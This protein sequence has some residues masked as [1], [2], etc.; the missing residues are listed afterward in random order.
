MLITREIDYAMRI[1]R[2][3]SNGVQMTAGEI[4][5]QQQIPQQF[6]YKIL[7]RLKGAGLI[8]ISRGADGGCRLTADLRNYTLYDLIQSMDGESHVSACMQDK[9]ECSWRR[10]NGRC[11]IHGQL[12][13]IQ[14]VL[15]ETLRA[16]TLYELLSGCD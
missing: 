13:G 16:H 1:L 14:R 4:S 5:A 7:K 10:D 6:T 12:T 15:N 3:L 8:S 11:D 9:F 2:A